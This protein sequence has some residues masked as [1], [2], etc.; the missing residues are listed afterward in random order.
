M[1]LLLK[2]V[3]IEIAVLEVQVRAEIH[4]SLKRLHHRRVVNLTRITILSTIFLAKGW[5]AKAYTRGTAVMQFLALLG[6]GHANVWK[7]RHVSNRSVFPKYWKM[8]PTACHFILFRVYILLNYVFWRRLALL[9]KRRK[10][11]EE[12]IIHGGMVFDWSKLRT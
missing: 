7:I 2:K 4:V 12:D 3:E 9:K 6:F 1:F 11:F 10:C 8:Y 5:E